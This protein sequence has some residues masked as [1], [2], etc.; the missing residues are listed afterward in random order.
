[1][2]PNR[3]FLR[4]RFEFL[5]SRR[6]LAHGGFV[7][8]D[9]AGL[10]S[11]VGTSKKDR[12]EVSFEND[13]FVVS[14]NGKKESFAGASVLSLSIDGKSGNDSITLADSV[15]LDALIYGGNGHDTIRG[16]G[17]NDWIYGGNGHDW[18]DG[19]LGDDWLDGAQGHD[20]LSGGDGD[21]TL[22]GGVGHD[23]LSGGEGD[24]TLNGG[25][26]NDELSG[27]AG[28]DNLDGGKGHDTLKGGDGDDS[29]LGSGGHDELFGDAGNDW[30]DGGAGHDKLYGGDGDDKLKGGTGHDKLD[31]GAGVNLLDGDSGKNTLTN[32]TEVDFESLPPPPPPPPPVD[33][34]DAFTASLTPWNSTVSQGTATWERQQTAAGLETFLLVVIHSQGPDLFLPVFI[35]G[36]WVGEINTA[37]DGTGSLKLSN[38]VD[39]P[40]EQPFPSP[41]FTIVAG[42]TIWIGEGLSGTFVAA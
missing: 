16:G 4:P 22:E 21:D 5:E 41:D 10:L 29:L 12:I 32:G 9:D 34:F 42:T 6:V 28:V 2:R 18:A 25:V 7:G 26:G 40:G 27:D 15:L 23:K 20:T 30:L 19:G 39:E 38:I 1:M 3:R 13:E 37:M 33:P 8:L 36:N 17:G 31:G 11:V 24:D 14:L 35:N